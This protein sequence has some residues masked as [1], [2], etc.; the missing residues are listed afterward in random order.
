MSTYSVFKTKRE[1]KDNQQ[2][3]DE[4]TKKLGEKYKVGENKASKGAMKFLT[5]NNADYVTIKK[6]A[7]HAVSIMVTP[8]HESVDYQTISWG[9]YV[10][11]TIVNQLI[12]GSGVLDILIAKLIFGSGKEFYKDVEEFITKDLEGVGVDTGFINSA[13]QLLKGKTVCDDEP[14]EENK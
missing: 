13:K 7:Y 12:G 6:N 11:N 4:V 3:L 8:K 9:S 2:L 1:V 14:T 10:P 5:G